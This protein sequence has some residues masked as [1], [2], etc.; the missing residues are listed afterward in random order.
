HGRIDRASESTEWGTLDQIRAPVVGNFEVMR[1]L[2]AEPSRLRQLGRLEE[3]SGERFESLSDTFASR[4]LQGFVR[5]C[6][7]DLH[8]RN[9][10]VWQGRVTPFDCIEFNPGFRWIDTA[11]EIAFLMMDLDDHGR[12]DLRRRFLNKYLEETGDFGC[13]LVLRFYEAYRAAVRAKV[14]LLRLQQGVESRLEETQIVEEWHRYLD[15]AESY[16]E[17]TA[18]R[19]IITHGLSGSGKTF[20][21]ERLLDQIDAIRIRSDI[22]RHRGSQTRA[23]SDRYSDRARDAVYDRLADLANEIL[24]AGYSVIVDATFLRFRQRQQFLALAQQWKIPFEIL[25]FDADIDTL[26]ARIRSRQ[27]DASE[28]T[29]AVLEEQIKSREPLRPEE[30]PFVTTVA[31]RG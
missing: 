3:W 18:P 23:E 31:G 27:G 20:G 16:A 1:P 21:T 28:A 2:I 17:P 15:L 11:S 26:R 19:L 25:P 12:A 13:L 24:R 30:E 5:E 6:H 29:V 14:D 4:R 7:G 22:E 9:I 8:L 10:V